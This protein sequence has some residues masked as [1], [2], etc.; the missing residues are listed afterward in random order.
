MAFTSA[1]SVGMWEPFQIAWCFSSAY[2]HGTLRRLLA[3]G[4]QAL[5]FLS[6]ALQ[7]Q[8]LINITIRTPL[9]FSPVISSLPFR[10]LSGLQPESSWAL[11]MELCSRRTA[12]S[13]PKTAE[14]QAGNRAGSAAD[15]SDCQMSLRNTQTPAPSSVWSLGT[16]LPE[17]CS[18]AIS[19]GAAP[20]G[21]S[22]C[23]GR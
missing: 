8:L 18:V 16:I 22:R 9:P 23:P 21:E 7:Q 3:A 4:S 1:C 2:L 17:C 5:L 11:G 12:P 20:R 15:A 14:Q 6:S 13:S 19:E 10:N